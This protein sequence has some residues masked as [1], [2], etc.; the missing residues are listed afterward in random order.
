MLKNKNLTYITL[1]SSGGVGCYGFK[2]E[3]YHCIATNELLK[4]RIN[5]QKANNICM[6]E[7]GYIEG[8][9][10]EQQ[11]KSKI[12]KEISKWKKIGND[13][14]DVILATPPCQGISVINHKKNNND[15]KRN[16]LVIESVE[17]VKHI[18]PR[19]FIFENVM[20]FQKTYCKPNDHKL[21]PIGDY[22]QKSL[23]DKY[24]ITGRIINLMN[25]GS[26]SSRTRTLLI[27]VDKKYRNSIT[28]FDLFPD[29]QYEKKLRHVKRFLSCL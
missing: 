8:D 23:G 28:P 20:A 13:R 27:G 17:I 26:N 25:Y 14:V 12:Y 16:S 3:N 5:V 7:S 10:S 22:I 11:I 21:I 2:Q 19:F 9:I 6:F 15:I 18:F 4:Q 24:L 29:Y 1:F